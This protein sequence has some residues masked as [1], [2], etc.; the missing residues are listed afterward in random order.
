[1]LKELTEAL[2]PWPILQLLLGLAAVGVGVYA[3][4]KG[5][6]NG[7]KEED[8][9]VDDMRATWAAYDQLK[10][11][12]HNVAKIV[13]SQEKMVEVVNRL[14]AVIWNRGQERD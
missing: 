12:D 7:R 6:S 5:T 4:I 8:I 10:N 9:N 14:A 2:G 11:I 1:M 3:M 13:A